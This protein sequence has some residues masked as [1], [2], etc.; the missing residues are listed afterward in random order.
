MA[1]MIGTTTHEW[2]HHRTSITSYDG[3]LVKK[4]IYTMN[5]TSIRSWCKP[6]PLSPPIRIKHLGLSHQKKQSE[7][8]WIKHPLPTK[9][10]TLLFLLF[11]PP[12]L[13][14]ELQPREFQPT[15]CRGRSYSLWCSPLSLLSL[16][17]SLS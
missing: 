10:K 7:K 4:Y 2:G 13:R 16:S 11:P 5:S 6:A 3:C 9:N 12:S 1:I 8:H 14:C 17:L 15:A